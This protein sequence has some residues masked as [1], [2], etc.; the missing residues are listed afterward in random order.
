MPDFDK[1]SPDEQDAMIERLLQL[2][3]EL[4]ASKAIT[5]VEHEELSGFIEFHRG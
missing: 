2:L 5:T 4:K 1:L 3:D